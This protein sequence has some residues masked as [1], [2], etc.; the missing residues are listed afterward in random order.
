[1]REE[2]LHQ[3]EQENAAL[4]KENAVLQEELATLRGLVAQLSTQVKHLENHLAKSSQNSHLP[5][6]SDRFSRQVRAK[7]L[8][9]K[10]G[11]QPGAQEGHEGTT[12]KQTATPDHLI[13]HEVHT[14][15]ACQRDLREGNERVQRTASSVGWA[16]QAAG[17]DRASSGAEICPHCQQI[18]TAAFPD[19]VSAPVQYGPALLAIGVYLVQ[20]QFLPYERA[21]ETMQDLLGPAMTV[22]T[23]KAAV[24]RCAKEVQPV[25]T[26]IKQALESS[27]GAACGRGGF[28][29]DGQAVLAAYH[30]HAHLDVLRCAS[31]TGRRGACFHWSAHLLCR[32]GGA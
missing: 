16:T 19:G 22:G 7:S 20:A 30:G 15:A 4:R 17:G 25:Q 29:R 24:A 27:P 31:Q 6:S 13:V 5:P 14:C 8:R 18:T 28:V 23:L 11:K 9:Q 21:G 10:S 2:D 12:L 3:L 32:R 1:M 26:Q